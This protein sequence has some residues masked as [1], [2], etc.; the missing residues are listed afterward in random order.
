LGGNNTK[1]RVL[2]C[3]M[4]LRE[5]NL[6]WRVRQ[7]LPTVTECTVV[8]INT[9][10]NLEAGIVAG[11]RDRYGLQRPIPMMHFFLLGPPPEGC[12]FPSTLHS[13]AENRKQAFNK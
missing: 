2:S 12:I 1:K 3:L 13:N 7:A 6:S 11:T 4:L 8:A 9:V 10:V 5:F